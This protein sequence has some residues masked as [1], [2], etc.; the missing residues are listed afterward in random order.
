[1]LRDFCLTD[2]SPLNHSPFR[3]APYPKPPDVSVDKLRSGIGDQPGKSKKCTHSTS[4]KKECHQAKSNLQ[5]LFNLIKY[6]FL[7]FRPFNREIYDHEGQPHTHD[8]AFLAMIKN[9]LADTSVLS[10]RP[11]TIAS[12]PPASLMAV[13]QFFQLNPTRYKETSGR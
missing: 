11:R 6:D 4:S 9:L 12:T 1:M 8:L 2:H 3:N 5:S 13:E 7:R 10:S